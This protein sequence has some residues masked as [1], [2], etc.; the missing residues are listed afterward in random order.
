MTAR[1]QDLI[2]TIAQLSI[3]EEFDPIRTLNESFVLTSLPSLEQIG[4]CFVTINLNNQ[5]R[6][7][8]GSLE[9]HRSLYEDIVFN[10][11][12]AAFADPRF[13]P[14]NFFEYQNLEYEISILSKTTQIDYTDMDD[15]RQKIRPNVDGVII[16]FGNKS[17][18]F[19]PQVWED[20]KYF[21]D[22]FISL[23][24]KAD[25]APTILDDRP[26]IKTYQVDKF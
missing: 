15:L 18:T 3:L 17:A 5:L 6:G 19:L 7:C 4:A 13:K 23:A 8:I 20:L 24:Q 14:I 9:A 1:D 12:S 16:E 11:K 22:F 26:I 25:L 2:K 10:A 21:D